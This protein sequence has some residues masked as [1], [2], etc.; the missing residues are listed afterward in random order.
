MVR[1]GF[2]KEVAAVNGNPRPVDRHATP[3]CN[4][5]LR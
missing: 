4:Q 3:C 1:N 5:L 2:I